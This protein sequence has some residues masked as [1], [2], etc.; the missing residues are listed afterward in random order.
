MAAVEVSI[1]ELLLAFNETIHQIH[2]AREPQVPGCAS[3]FD[4]PP[5]VKADQRASW[6][7]I[8]SAA[9]SLTARRCLDEQ[10]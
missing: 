3:E 5:N 10:T 7:G 1:R 2:S 8:R 9:D 6:G 4:A